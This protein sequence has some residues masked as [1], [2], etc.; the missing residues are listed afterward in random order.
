MNTL[1]NYRD[2]WLRLQPDGEELIKEYYNIA[3]IIVERLKSSKNYS[4]YCEILWDNYL[5]PCLSFI[6][7][8]EYELCKKRYI[9]MFNYLYFELIEKVI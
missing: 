2:N 8:K 5:Q 1:R 3:P 7:K 6:D 4:E 9:E